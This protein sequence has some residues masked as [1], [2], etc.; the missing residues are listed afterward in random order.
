MQ[1][2]ARSKRIE[3]VRARPV[4]ELLECPPATGLLL[5]GAAQCIRFA[6]GQTVF[7]QS[8]TCR[9]L[10]LVVSGHF[11]REI[12][13]LETL[14]TLSPARAGDLVELAAALGDGH[15]TYT[16][17]AH[18]AGSLLMLPIETLNQAFQSYPPLRMHLLEELAREVTRA[19]YDCWLSR[20]AVHRRERSAA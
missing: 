13:R 9:G 3:T 10:Y 2:E 16:L 8:E 7:C 17:T 18:S 11:A 15:H 19:Y 1:R 4:A 14:L 5:N 20:A 12:E 6:A